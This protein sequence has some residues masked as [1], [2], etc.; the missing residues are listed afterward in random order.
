MPLAS[1]IHYP[2]KSEWLGRPKG[3]HPDVLS[4]SKCPFMGFEP[5]RSFLR[6][7]VGFCRCCA[8]GALCLGSTAEGIWP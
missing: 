1:I 8:W 4:L 3:S 7:R 6:L 5:I 2:E